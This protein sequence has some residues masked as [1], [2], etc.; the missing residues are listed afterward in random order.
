MCSLNDP[1]LRVC[2]SNILRKPVAYQWREVILKSPHFVSSCQN[3]CVKIVF[4]VEEQCLNN[5]VPSCLLIG[6]SGSKLPSMLRAS[7]EFNESTAL[8]TGF[9]FLLAADSYSVFP[10]L[11]PIQTS[12]PSL[13]GV[14][15]G[16]D[17]KM[18]QDVDRPFIR[19]I[20][21]LMIEERAQLHLYYSLSNASLCGPHLSQDWAP[22]QNTNQVKFFP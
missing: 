15:V 9:D 6:D 16:I 2:I 8:R 4:E 13:I 20:H 7:L 17:P 18:I 10:I 14:A 5:T 12:R 11:I 1:F 22:C 19:G 3:A 21:T